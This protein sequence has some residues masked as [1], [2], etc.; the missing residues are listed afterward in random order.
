MNGYK[1]A[2]IIFGSEA[3]FLDPKERTTA[4]LTH[5]WRCYVKVAPAL[6]KSVQFRLHESFANPYITI[7]Q[8]PFE[9]SEQGWGEFTINIKITLFNDEKIT[10]SHHL[11]LHGPTNPVINERIDTILYKGKNIKIE[12]EYNFE[13]E[14][15]SDEFRRINSAI[16]HIL[17]LFENNPNIS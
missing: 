11:T 3:Y 13:Y 16:E 4:D 17:E 14:G 1:K 15:E 10:T 5:S 2:P 9:I 12:E 8:P 6:V 7:L